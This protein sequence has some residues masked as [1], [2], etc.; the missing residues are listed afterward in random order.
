MA[1]PMLLNGRSS[2]ADRQRLHTY[3]CFLEN[4]DRACLQRFFNRAQV[5]EEE[6]ELPVG[7]A[8]PY[9]P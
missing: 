5:R 3:A 2:A 8:A 1:L 9:R 6:R 4:D 7:D